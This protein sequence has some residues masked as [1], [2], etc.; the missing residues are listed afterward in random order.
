[1]FNPH[2]SS[3]GLGS[4][5]LRL[6]ALP[7]CLLCVVVALAS[8][9]TLPVQATSVLPQVVASEVICDN[10]SPCFSSL[11]SVAAWGY[12]PFGGVGSSGAYTLHAYWTYNSLNSAIDWGLWQPTLPQAGTYDVYIW[13]PHFPGTAPET[14]SARYQVHHASGD[15]FVTWNQ[16]VNA[17]MWN[18]L[19]T[20]N[21]VAG[22][23]CY[24]R[25]T[26]ATSET[27]G[28][29][30]VWFDA[31]R[32]VLTTYTVTGVVRDG[33]G[34]GMAGVT[35][36]DGTRTAVTDG[37]GSYT[38]NAVPVG[39]YT[40]TPTKS[41]YSFAPGSLGLT[42]A[43]NLSGQNF[44]GTLLTYTVSGRIADG[45]STGIAGVTVADG[46]RSAVTDSSGTY[47]LTGVLPGSYTLTPTKSGYSFSTA[48]RNVTVS[49]S[50]L[51]GQDFTGTLLTYTVSGRIVDGTST[52]I[53]GV[54]VADGTHTAI[55][56]VSGT[57]TLTGVLPGSYT[58]TPT[59]SG[60]SFSAA[61]RNV[62]VSASNL[63]GQDFTGTQNTYTV[64]G[65][66]VDSSSTGIAGVTVADGTR[67]AV[68]DSTGSYTLTGVLPGSYTLTPTK[69]GYS[70]STATRNIIVSASNLPGQD[71]IGTLI[72]TGGSWTFLLY[73]DGDTKSI[74]GGFVSLFLDDAIKRLE[75]NPN[76]LVRVV[77]LIDGPGNPDT[78]RI[79]FTPQAQ[80]QALGEK[81]MDDPATLI[82]F[83]QQAQQDFP[84]DHYY[85][86]IADHA[87]GIQGI[88][89]DT[90]T[91]SDSTAL[92]SPGKLR[93]ALSAITNDG[94]R[95]LDVVHFDGYSF[96]LLED[97]AMARGFARYV[98][99]SENISWGVF[100]YDRYRAAIGPNTTPS[101][102][103]RSVV[104][105]YAQAVGSHPY[106]ISA[107]DMSHFD[108]VLTRLNT[109]AD[110]LTAFMSSQTS[111]SILV[112]L[113][114]DS[115]KFDSGGTPYLTINDDDV[116]VDLVDF[117]ARAKQKIPSDGVPAAADDLITAITGPQPFVLAE[118]HRSGSFEDDGKPYTWNLD[119]AHG[120][121][122]YY[123]P[124]SAGTPFV[125]YSNG[126]TFPDF[127]ALSH[128][129]N[130]L[131][132][133][134]PPLAPGEPP[135]SDVMEPLTPL[136]PASRY[137]VYLPMLRR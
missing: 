71:F 123:P 27:S 132:V 21:C 39:S 95:P 55:T 88:A 137:N 105:G 115:Q 61:T 2:R 49:A 15:Q 1:M 128:W 92:L 16:A 64:S 106:T 4:R 6:L 68:T 126:V 43:N 117:A 63:P 67:T 48:T 51:P 77:A 124:R 76:A 58:L 129:K 60:Y 56:D 53:A 38:L 97:A 94:A 12:V 25:L 107:L 83:V 41:G 65:R 135:P 98:V 131:R 130:Y 20:V 84:A 30:R 23:A 119:G 32:F 57:Y 47:T 91:A 86:A 120:I 113:R 134:V 35:V 3:W 81:P 13:Y 59:K 7:L 42:V 111:T 80:Y 69:S 99:A 121:S 101:A 29:R 104:E 122:V 125:A 46:T 127:T 31:V 70:F 17:G 52:G 22:A 93:Q 45:T 8:W 14:N 116:Y 109:F 75:T 62:T 66:I 50:N 34:V 10:Q 114:K 54:T 118:K 28:T 37:T 44:T 9:A 108:A 72:E 74:D 103:A 11:Q 100:A 40:L 82:A 89:W 133:S 136:R 110:G 112:G 24:V 73:L 18:K 5:F 26:D 19:T 33:G 79:T 96:G 102:L 90:T 87:N 36:S 85:L 78:F